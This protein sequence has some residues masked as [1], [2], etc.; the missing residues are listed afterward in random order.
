MSLQS[1]DLQGLLPV[2]EP[3]SPEAHALSNL[4]IGV[5]IVAAAIFVLVTVLVIHALI[6]YRGREGDR[7]PPFG[8]VSYKVEIGWTLTPLLLLAIIFGFTLRTISEVNPQPPP[9]ARPDIVIR[10]HQ[11]WWQA[12]YPESGV[13]A[14]NEI[15]IPTNQRI[16][17]RI[18]SA[19]VIHDFWVPSLARKID[20]IPG[21]KNFVW[22]QAD[23]AGTYLGRCAEYCG[24]QHAHMQVLVIAE[25]D[26]AF[27][28]WQA[29]QLEPPVRPKTGLQ[30]RGLALLAEKACLGCHRLG[31]AGRD[32]GPDLTHIASRRTLAAVTLKNTPAN[33]A[34]WL[35]N[36]SAVKPGT[37][38]PDFE[39]TDPEIAALVA[40]LGALR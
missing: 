29:A 12:E 10:G 32:V 3:A 7:D 18:E 23:S 4:F 27:S 24:A 14:A 35:R 5:S 30:R 2:F 25:P 33:L 20:M 19:D 40:Y 37:I 39:L 31:R 6:R 28:A 9:D 13:V 36:P 1:E 8:S 16:L 15:H 22:L 34:R 11:W 26:S 17:A 38:M 21:R